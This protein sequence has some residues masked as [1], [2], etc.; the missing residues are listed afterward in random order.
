MNVKRVI[1]AI[2]SVTDTLNNCGFEDQEHRI[3]Q[4]NDEE[5]LAALEAAWVI[6]ATRASR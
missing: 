6:L 1:A 5:K 2:D 4:L 3:A